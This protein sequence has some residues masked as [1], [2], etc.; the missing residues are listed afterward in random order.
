MESHDWGEGKARVEEWQLLV[1]V[2]RRWRN[3]VFRSPRR[4]NLR[5]YCTPETPAKDTLDIWPAFPLI[6]WGDI[7]SSG[8]D[9]IIAALEQRNRVSHVYL[10]NL[11]NWQSETVLA[12]MQAPFLELEDLRLFSADADET[13]LVIPDSLLGGSAP[14]LQNFLLSGISFPGLTKLLLTA[15]RLVYLWLYDIPHSGYISPEAIVDLFSVLSSLEDLSISFQSPRSHPGGRPQSSQPPKRTILPALRYFEF[16]GVTEYLEELVIRIGTPQLNEMKITFFNQIDF[17]TPRLAQF[18]NCTPTLR[19]LDEAHVHVCAPGIARMGFR[20]RASEYSFGN[21]SINI[22]CSDPDW[23]LSSIEQVCNSLHPLSKVEDLYIEGRARYPLLVWKDDPIKNTL[24]LQ[25]LLRFTAVK[26]LYLSVVFA[27][28]IAATLKELVTSGVIELLPSLQNIFV[29]GL[30]Q[31]GPSW[32]NIE[33]F[34]AA[35]QLSD[36]PIAISVCDQWQ[37]WDT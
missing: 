21:L 27:P 13:P 3:V 7:K 4:L 18:I 20:Y 26:N 17:N 2:C 28:R 22:S 15:S 1:H 35:R 12:T 30:D 31:S 5:L 25:L 11:A 8:A 6:V 23:Q 24:W 34:V 32:E 9:N 37:A 29:A 33:Q 16:K 14:H 36:N 10:F 19:A